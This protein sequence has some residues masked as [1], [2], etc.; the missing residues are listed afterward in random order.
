MKSAKTL[1]D[2]KAK[3]EA[4]EKGKYP[5]LTIDE[6]KELVVGDKWL[7][8][9][10]RGIDELYRSVSAALTERVTTLANR[11]GRPLGKI[12]AECETLEKSVANRLRMWIG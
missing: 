9:V 2:A 11:Y 7:A 12:E 4:L 5:T 3:L 1:K 8:T 10:W 6:I